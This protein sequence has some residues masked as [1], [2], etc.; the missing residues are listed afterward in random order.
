MKYLTFPAPYDSEKCTGFHALQAPHFWM[1]AFLGAR[2]RPVVFHGRRE[3]PEPCQGWCGM[4]R[5]RANSPQHP[6]LGEAILAL[7]TCW[8]PHGPQDGETVPSFLQPT[9]KSCDMKWRLSMWK[10]PDSYWKK[11]NKRKKK[12]TKPL[13]CCHMP[14]LALLQFVCDF[15][16]ALPVAG[17][18]IS[19]FVLKHT[20][21][22]VLSLF[23]HCLSSLYLMQLIFIH[24]YFT[25]KG[26]TPK[27]SLVLHRRECFK[28]PQTTKPQ[29]PHPASVPLSL[30][31]VEI[32]EPCNIKAV[33]APV[34][35][36][37][38]HEMNLTEICF[39]ITRRTILDK[40]HL[41]PFCKWLW[42]HSPMLD[43]H[44]LKLATM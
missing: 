39:Y 17:A 32:L 28:K 26:K 10:S 27:N 25:G 5:R 15:W 2:K 12:P 43:L 34:S 6:G 14:S 16:A 40:S 30:P 20:L 38:L 9:M 31:Q 18:G 3:I 8:R 44:G 41:S 29:T 23:S 36:E 35:I 19:H 1:S 42:S 24:P 11:K 37:C 4:R 22:D 7:G 33:W 21:K 13:I